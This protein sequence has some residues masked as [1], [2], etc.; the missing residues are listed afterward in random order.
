MKTKT[1]IYGLDAS[2]FHIGGF[3]LLGMNAQNFLHPFRVYLQLAFLWLYSY[4]CISYR[5]RP[6]RRQAD[7]CSCAFLHV[8]TDEASVG[9]SSEGQTFIL[10]F[11]ALLL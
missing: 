3:L 11:L 9:G 2:L 10:V 8:L 1:A 7:A 5:N 6:G 4:G